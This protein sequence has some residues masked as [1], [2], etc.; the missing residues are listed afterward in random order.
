MPWVQTRAGHKAE[1]GVSYLTAADKVREGAHS[2]HPDSHARCVL[3]G[4]ILLDRTF[5]RMGDHALFRLLYK[6]NIPRPPCR[7]DT[8]Q[9]ANLAHKISIH[10]SISDSDCDVRC[11]PRAMSAMT[12]H[13]PAH[14]PTV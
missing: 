6:L 8:C 9:E 11:T 2:L 13:E 14:P 12:D 10:A 4:Q 7:R 3:L 5:Y 1:P